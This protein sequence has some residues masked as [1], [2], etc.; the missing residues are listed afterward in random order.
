MRSNKTKSFYDV[1]CYILIS[2]F[3]PRNRYAKASKFDGKKI[4]FIF[5]ERKKKRLS[6]LNKKRNKIL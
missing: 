4:I 3:A 2:H 6:I 5:S 1:G